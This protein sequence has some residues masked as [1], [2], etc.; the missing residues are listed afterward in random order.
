MAN[1]TTYKQ[2]IERGGFPAI[3]P[4][5]GMIEADV[6]IGGV[7][8]SANHRAEV[9]A[10]P[11]DT[12][13]ISAGFEVITASTNSVTAS[14]GLDSSGAGSA[15][16][17]MGETSTAAA[18]GT[19]VGGGYAKANVVLDSADELVLEISGDAGAAGAV[20]VWAIVADTDSMDD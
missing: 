16:E 18:A 15:T 11:A 2:T 3:G 4:K 7:L 10:L 20:R 14:L 1:V 13:V 6:T 9:F 17:F 19:N 12:M 8:T 5:I